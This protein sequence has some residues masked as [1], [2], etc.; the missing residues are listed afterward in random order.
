MRVQLAMEYMAATQKRRSD[1]AVEWERKR[2][3]DVESLDAQ[4]QQLAAAVAEETSTLE[5]CHICA[6][7]LANACTCSACAACIHAV[8]VHCFVHTSMA[9]R[10]VVPGACSCVLALGFAPIY[11]LLA[12]LGIGP[13]ADSGQCYRGRARHSSRLTGSSSCLVRQMLHEQCKKEWRSKS[14]HEARELEKIAKVVS[15]EH[16]AKVIQRAWRH[17]LKQPR[18]VIKKA[19]VKKGKKGKKG[20]ASA[21]KKTGTKA[22]S[23]KKAAGG[24]KKSAAAKPAAAKK[25][26]GKAAGA[27]K[28]AKKK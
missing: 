21:G 2:L 12:E 10:A 4:L 14:A 25:T 6:F 18:V 1:E 8:L 3:A 17:H 7:V 15:R 5:V 27:K 13:D 26:G 9:I 23:G 24:A 20:A 19:A 28:A 16:S 22:A 11:R